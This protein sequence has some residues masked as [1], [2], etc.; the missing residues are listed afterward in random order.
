MCWQGGR[1]ESGEAVNALNLARKSE[2]QCQLFP[3]RFLKLPAAARDCPVAARA[4]AVG[5]RPAGRGGAG[6]A[7]H[8]PPPARVPPGTEYL[9]FAAAAPGAA[10]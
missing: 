7:R 8:Q 4:A 6:L 2:A 10:G 5:G 9:P 1:G 3:E